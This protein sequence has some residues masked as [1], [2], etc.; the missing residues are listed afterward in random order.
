ML[1]HLANLPPRKMLLLC[2]V[3]AEVLTAL[4]VCGFSLLFRGEIATDYLI[5]GAG[6]S[7][8]VAAVVVASLLS[9]SK[10]TRKA[11]QSRDE[12]EEK[13]RLLFEYSRDAM[14]MFA[15]ETGEVIE[16]NQAFW[17]LLNREPGPLTLDEFIAHDGDS[18]SHHVGRIVEYG[19][20]DLKARQWRSAD[21]SLRDVEVTGHRVRLAGRDVVA[22]VARD[23][24]ARL[25]VN[26][27]REHLRE[28]LFTAQKLEAI[29]Q[30]AG[31]I[32]HDFNNLMGGVLA[33]TSYLQHGTQ[34][35][36]AD[37]ATVREVVADIEG[38]ARRAAELTRQLMTFARRQPPVIEAV[39][40]HRLTGEVTSLLRRAIDPSIEVHAT[41]PEG[42]AVRADAGHLHQVV[43]NLAINARDAMPDGGKLSIVAAALPADPDPDGEQAGR[44]EMIISDTGMG[45]DT[46]TV[47]RVFEPFFT[48]KGPESGTGLG[49]AV[50]YGIVAE[51]GGQIEVQS[52][53]GVGTSVRVTLAAA[54][55]E[56][57]RPAA[58]VRTP[59]GNGKVLVIDDDGLMRRS[60]GRVLESLGYTA[61]LAR[62]GEHGLAIFSAGRARFDAVLLDMLMPGMDGSQTYEALAAIDANVP[63]LVMSGY[64]EHDRIQRVLD[65]GAVGALSKPFDRQT[66]ARTLHEVLAEHRPTE[67]D[68]RVVSA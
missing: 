29:G 5:T 6:T 44:V 35:A 19:F 56:A 54:T 10:R 50:V 18:V 7:G 23:I 57:T 58:Q 65:A 8:V 28:Q 46:E 53:P 21:G 34:D 67:S 49:L 15:P 43:M 11:E 51:H 40:L 16:G 36:P 20:L 63:V 30:L 1:Q 64:V 17:S 13:H 68:P 38:A 12:S 41:V 33:S 42:L 9:L 39:D 60:V 62:D 52:Q 2:L 47:S 55:P 14:Y 27:E 22:I 48:S 25:R 24:T 3:V 66:L 32:A 37:D 31:G 59:T 4:I 61:V 45:M 26:Q